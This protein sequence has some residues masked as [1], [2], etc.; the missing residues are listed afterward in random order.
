MT[1]PFYS[2][3]ALERAAVLKSGKQFRCDGTFNKA[4]AERTCNQVLAETTGGYEPR[5]GVVIVCRRCGKR[6]EL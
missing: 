5:S 3:N 2:R 4:G 1:D 6:H